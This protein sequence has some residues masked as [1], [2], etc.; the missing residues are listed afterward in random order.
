[1]ALA[2]VL[3]SL[4]LRLKPK[5]SKTQEQ[6]TSP[7]DSNLAFQGLQVSALRGDDRNPFSFAKNF[8]PEVP[9]VA[10]KFPL[11]LGRSPCLAAQ[12]ER[13]PVFHQPSLPLSPFTICAAS[14]GWRVQKTTQ[15]SEPNLAVNNEARK[16]NSLTVGCGRTSNTSNKCYHARTDPIG[17]EASCSGVSVTADVHEVT[18]VWPGAAFRVAMAKSDRLLGEL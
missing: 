3:A 10:G 15:N 1:M 18:L 6:K 9:I 7:N 13:V 16:L 8:R 11:K 2:R 5:D 14:K 17:C 12:N 4:R